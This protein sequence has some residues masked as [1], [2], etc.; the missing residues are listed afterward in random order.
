LG[1]LI[2]KSIMDNRL[3][4]IPLSNAFFKLILGEKLSFSDL[5]DISEIGKDIFDLDEA[6]HRMKSI[7]NN[8][9]L[10][11]NLIFLHMDPN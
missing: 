10:V 9:S 1:Q 3:L 5:R 4:D 2:A 8:S 11:C 6:Y 7:Q